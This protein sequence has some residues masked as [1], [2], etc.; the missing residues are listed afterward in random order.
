MAWLEE[1]ILF[2]NVEAMAELARRTRI[3]VSTGEQL[4]TRWEFQPLLQSNAVGIIQPD[5]CH[6]GGISELKKIAAAAETHY[7]AVA[8]H[9][10]N[11][12]ISTVASVHL[13]ASL[14]NLFMQEIFLDFLPAYQELLTEPLVIRDGSFEVPS[15]PGWGTDLDL[16]AV[17]ARPPVDYTP[18]SSE[19]YLAF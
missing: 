3:P 8:P 12:P 7:V 11:G 4:Y 14:P 10:S 9:N 2:D 18:V 6:A 19:P 5:L 1:P 13:D 17:G 16:D 15:G